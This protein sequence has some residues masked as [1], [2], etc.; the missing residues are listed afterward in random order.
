MS[1]ASTLIAESDQQLAMVSLNAG[2]L[3][4]FATQI[5]HKTQ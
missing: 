1:L 5:A 2:W 4:P 3:A